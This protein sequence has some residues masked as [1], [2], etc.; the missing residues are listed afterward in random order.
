M[1][2][3]STLNSNLLSISTAASGVNQNMQNMIAAVNLAISGIK[4]VAHSENNFDT[5]S[6]I[7]TYSRAGILSSLS[8]ILGCAQR[9]DTIGLFIA[10]NNLQG[11]LNIE[12]PP[13][14]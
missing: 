8:I 4:S 9:G 5:S 7:T 10:L 2:W 6:F 1:S 11:F 3:L 12:L 14:I 13:G